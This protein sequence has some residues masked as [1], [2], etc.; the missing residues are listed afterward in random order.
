[1]EGAELVASAHGNHMSPA[2]PISELEGGSHIQFPYM[3]F[4]LSF[5]GVVISCPFLCSVPTLSTL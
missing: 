2:F 1:M 5:L 3:S 4:P